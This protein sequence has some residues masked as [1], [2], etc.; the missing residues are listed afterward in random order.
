[1]AIAKNQ[2]KQIISDNNI[3]SISDIY[4][5]FKESFKDMLQELLEA[6]MD[7][8][9]E[10]SKNGKDGLSTDNKRNGY[11]TKTIKS[12][13]GESPIEIPRDCNSEFEP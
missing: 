11:S 12:Q 1:M 6:E 2:L 10:Y 3:T 9:I 7:A 13:Y 4:S 8:S 5:L